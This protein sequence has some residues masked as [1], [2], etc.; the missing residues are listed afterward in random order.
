MDTCYTLITAHS[1]CNDT[2]PNTPE[3]VIFGMESGADFVEVD[4]RST[5]D[6]LTV[7]FHDDVM[8]TVD[9]GA[10]RI[11]DH[12]LTELN[13]LIKT[14]SKESNQITEIITLNDAISIAN[15]FG[16]LL[17]VD[18][19]DD[20]CIVP[21]TK[22]VKE[23]NMVD[24]VIITGC[25]YARAVSLKKKYPEFQVLLNIDEQQ[26]LDKEKSASV[27]AE[28]ICRMA[29]KAS[30]CGINIKFKYL[31]EE[32]VQTARRR[33]LPISIWTLTESENLD[34]YLKMGLFSITTTAVSLLVEKRKR[35]T[36]KMA[37]PGVLPEKI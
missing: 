32:L 2:P 26:L 29:V 31:T 33:F 6:G 30:C 10:V 18:V 34:D 4:V 37:L 25:E 11:S 3:S 7:L 24:S 21:M 12:T 23:A 22:A 5:K 8:K 36:G 20:Q 9:H 17:N 28:E 15:D 35:H 1:G 27:I 13:R 19:K 16:G 14:D